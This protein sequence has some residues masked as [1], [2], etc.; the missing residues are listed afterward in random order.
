[1][2]RLV[3]RRVGAA[4]AALVVLLVLTGCNIA[5][6]VVVNPNGSGTY[7]V[8][9]TVPKGKAAGAVLGALQKAAAKSRV[10]LNVTPVSLGG[11][12]GAKAT[13]TFQSLRDLDAESAVVASSGDGLG[14]N[15][16][17][18]TGGWHFTA[19][20]ANG[21]TSP[22]GGS[23]QVSTGG[24]ISGDALA[25]I[26]TISVIVQ[27]PGTP[28]QNNATSVAHSSTTST[29]TWNLQIGRAN[30]GLQASTTFVGNQANVRLSSALTPIAPAGSGTSSGSGMSGT[31]IA[32]IAG[33]AIV[34]VL[35]VGALVL[36]RRRKTTPDAPQGVAG[37]AGS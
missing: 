30:A 9:L 13:F 29:F 1:M 31:T 8:I 17:R 35:G 7:S 21:L 22:P 33:G 24:P 26:A 32:L 16:H 12:A 3:M 34:V 36:S 18:D 37:S 15:I 23:A 6:K 27:L 20:S 28:A 4:G 25:S 19:A 10:P 11:E 14:V 5:S 2:E